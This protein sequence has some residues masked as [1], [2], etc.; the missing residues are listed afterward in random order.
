MEDMRF[1]IF[2]V[3][4]SKN[5]KSI[6]WTSIFT[7]IKEIKILLDVSLSFYPLTIEIEP[8]L[9]YDSIVSNFFV[10]QYA[11]SLKRMFYLKNKIT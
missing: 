11:S 1:S 8:S 4:V 7:R 10:L 6:I 3:I 9:F 2:L 5:T